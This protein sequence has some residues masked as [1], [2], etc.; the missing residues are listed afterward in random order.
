[1]AITDTERITMIEQRIERLENLVTRLYNASPS[2]MIDALSIE[3][4]QRPSPTPDP[5]D[6]PGVGMSL[7]D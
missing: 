6:L 3:L 5:Y 2:A 1:M 7:S 4:S